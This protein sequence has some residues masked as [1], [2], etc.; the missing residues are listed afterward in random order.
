MERD[1]MELTCECGLRERM[2]CAEYD[3]ALEYQCSECGELTTQV[4]FL[5]GAVADPP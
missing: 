1:L 2:Q 4:N 5:S 3:P